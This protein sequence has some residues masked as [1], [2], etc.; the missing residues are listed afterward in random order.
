MGVTSDVTK[1]AN[2]ISN[3]VYSLSIEIDGNNSYGV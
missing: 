2:I 3:F 1:N